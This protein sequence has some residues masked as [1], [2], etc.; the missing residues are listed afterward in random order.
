MKMYLFS[1]LS[2]SLSLRPL[3]GS[4]CEIRGTLTNARR[5]KAAEGKP[6]VLS[7]FGSFPPL[8]AG[9]GGGGVKGKATIHP[10]DLSIRG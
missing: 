6:R 9:G 7:R 1:L 5:A 4:F 2:L 3:S 8:L 10:A